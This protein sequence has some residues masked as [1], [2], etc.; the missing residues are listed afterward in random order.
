[1]A[2]EIRMLLFERL[3]KGSH[4]EEI[5]AANIEHELGVR[6]I[7]VE[8]REAIDLRNE[9]RKPAVDRVV[10]GSVLPRR[11]DRIL[12]DRLSGLR[13]A[14]RHSESGCKQR[15][16]KNVLCMPVAHAA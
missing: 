6:K 8:V 7:T 13:R 16:S 3:D 10:V 11:K 12:L 4:G 2:F 15:R 14:Q 9:E 1:V 5:I